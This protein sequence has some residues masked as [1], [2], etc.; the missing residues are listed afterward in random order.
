LLSVV[1]EELKCD[2]LA[3]YQLVLLLLG[4]LFPGRSIIFSRQKYMLFVGILYIWPELT[5]RFFKTPEFPQ[6]EVRD[7]K[8]IENEGG[9]HLGV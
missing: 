5:N 2:A 1:K 9:L 4:R 8:I 6:N 3:R 7:G